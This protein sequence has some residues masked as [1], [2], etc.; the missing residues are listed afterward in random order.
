M[1]L[2]HRLRQ[3]VRTMNPDSR[4]LL[5]ITPKWPLPADDGA[6]RATATLLT[7]LSRLGEKID[8]VAVC[9]ADEQVVSSEAQKELGVRSVF[10]VRRSAKSSRNLIRLALSFLSSPRVP[11]TMRGYC[12]P[13]ISRT[14]GNL[15][16]GVGASIDGANQIHKQRWSNVVYDGLHPAAH[17]IDDRT[18]RYKHQTGWP[19]VIYRAHNQEAKIWERKADGDS[20]PFT[21]IFLRDQTKRVRVF[22][23]SVLETSAGVA[24]VSL[25]DLEAFWEEVPGARGAVVPIGYTFEDPLP[26]SFSKSV[27]IM[28]LGRLDWPPNKE[29]LIWFLKDVWPTVSARRADI[30]LTIAGSGDGSWLDAYK[31]LPALTVLGRIESVE[32]LYSR[33]HC[34]IIPIFY[35][36]G[37]RV[38]AIEGCRYGRA[39]LSTT[40]GVEGLGLVP[41]DEYLRGETSAEWIDLLLR[42]S[43]DECFRV[44]RR[45]W[46]SARKRFDAASAAEEFRK[47]L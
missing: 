7:H 23:N 44:G 12:A 31:D 17:A 30:K 41:D 42:L 33:S 40:I 2:L 5:W 47:L 11:L 13:T 25:E 6:R 19:K 36:S 26:R 20:N 43:A 29:G 1:A 18:G 9:G 37:T 35:G 8:L 3:Y 28:F 39:L 22:E 46:E 38:K 24:T 15:L 16:S 21:R 32:D 14:L 10:V 27:E 34:S 45:G 4:S